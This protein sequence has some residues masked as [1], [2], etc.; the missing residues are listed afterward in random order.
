MP[1]G[2]RDQET[3]AVIVVDEGAELESVVAASVSM[4]LRDPV[5]APKLGIFYGLVDPLRV[6]E[7]E[8]IPGVLSVE[9]EG[10]IRLAPPN[11]P[12]Q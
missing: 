2:S 1:A 6:A 7:F 11:S 8:K 4:G 9:L 12:I 3:K 10:D 5:L